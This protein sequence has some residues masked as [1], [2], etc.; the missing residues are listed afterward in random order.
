M[1]TK[2]HQIDNGGDTNIVAANT[3]I[4]VSPLAT[5]LTALQ[6]L[7]H[8]V[9]VDSG[10]WVNP[11]TGEDLDR[12]DGE[13]LC[14]MHSELSEALEGLRKDLMDDHLTDRKCAEVELADCIIRIL[15]FAG[16]KGYDIGG[17]VIEKL[18]YNTLRSDHKPENRVKEGGKSF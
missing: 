8:G 15:D 18:Q 13:L 16:A 9:A 7:C 14:L 10:W 12:N 2:N 17:A 1:T 3:D 4:Y 5:E 6:S 11:D